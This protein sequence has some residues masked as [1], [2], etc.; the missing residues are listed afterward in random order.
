MAQQRW[1]LRLHFEHEAQARQGNTQ[2]T[3]VEIHVS[4]GSR[5]EQVAP[6]KRWSKKQQGAS[7]GRNNT[8]MNTRMGEKVIGDNILENIRFLLYTKKVVSWENYSNKEKKE[9]RT[10]H[11]MLSVKR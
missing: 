1:S 11:I 5:S 8:S 2:R 9:K 4:H 6:M 7:Q 10:A 3:F